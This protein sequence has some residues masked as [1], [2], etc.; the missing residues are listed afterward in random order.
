MGALRAQQE[1][2]LAKYERMGI[3]DKRRVRF[4]LDE[5]ARAKG[6]RSEVE[7]RE[8][9]PHIWMQMCADTVSRMYPGF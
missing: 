4:Q 9:K 5:L 2:A 1:M 8:K 6:Y 3:Q 7:L